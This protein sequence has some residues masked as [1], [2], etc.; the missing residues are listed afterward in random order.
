MA[1]SSMEAAAKKTKGVEQL[2]QMLN[3]PSVMEQF[4]NALQKNASTFV[5]SII[6]L[7]NSDSKLQLCE[8]RQVIMEAL[9]AAVLH[10]PINKALGYA[11]VIP[12]YNSKKVNDVDENGN[13]KVDATGRAVTKWVKVY[14]PTF[15]IGYKGLIQ[16]A[17]R[18]GQ[19]RTINAD[20]VY[21]GELRKVSK[22]KGEIAFDGEK[23]SDKVIGYFCY[24]ELMNGFSKSLFM[25]TEQMAAHAKLYSPSLKNDDKVTVESLLGFARLPVS[26]ESKTIGWT[27]NFHKM[28]IKTVIRNLLSQY[29]YLSTEMQNAIAEDYEAEIIETPDSTAKNGSGRQVLDMTDATYEEVAN[30]GSTNVNSINEPDY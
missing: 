17:I 26:Q 29:G 4:Q 12:F 21:E 18:T 30:D 27:G 7:Y 22:L 19:Y 9:K 24:F 13:P 23:K 15:Q 10:L 20:V 14:E 2:K 1:A 25:S 11:Y 6:D 28:A 8:P 3:A 16:L 5:A